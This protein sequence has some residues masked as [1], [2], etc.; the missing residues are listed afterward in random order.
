M[1]ILRRI[2]QVFG[3]FWVGLRGFQTDLDAS[4]RIK[5]PR[6]A[7]RRILGGFEGFE[8]DSEALSRILLGF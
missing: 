5:D 7:S 6:R 3:S 1:M 8:N 2:L 4:R